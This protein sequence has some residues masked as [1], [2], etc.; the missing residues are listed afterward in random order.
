MRLA[1]MAVRLESI[2]E[3][4]LNCPYCSTSFCEKTACDVVVAGPRCSELHQEPSCHRNK[5]EWY[6]GPAGPLP[7]GQ[8]TS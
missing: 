3:M 1:Q 2:L 4:I 6:L 8:E 7:L 5:P